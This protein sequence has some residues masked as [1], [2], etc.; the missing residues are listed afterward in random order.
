LNIFDEYTTRES[1]IKKLNPMHETSLP[2]SEVEQLLHNAQ[3]RDQLEPFFDESIAL[4]DVTEMSTSEENQFLASMLNWEYAPVL[5]ISQWFEPELS[6][7]LPETLSNR[8]LSK[9][10]W[11][12]LQRLAEQN[13]Y[14]QYTDHLSDRELFCI[15]V[16]DILTA[17]EKKLDISNNSIVWRLVDNES[18]PDIWL[19]YYATDEQR[20]LWQLEHGQAPPASKPLKYPRQMP[21]PA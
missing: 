8:D 9:M 14:L 4:V 17:T 3:L 21:R 15:L 7:P 12:T 1:L 10:L 6:L 2:E 5:P 16:R 11:D 20:Y 19:A 18:D 13:I